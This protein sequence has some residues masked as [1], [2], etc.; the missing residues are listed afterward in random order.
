MSVLDEGTSGLVATSTEQA[1]ITDWTSAVIAEEVQADIDEDPTDAL[2]R[3]HARKHAVI[4]GG[5]GLIAAPTSLES[6]MST[7]ELMARLSETREALRR[8][9][10]A[11]EAELGRPS[12][13]SH[14]D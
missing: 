12:G 14:T 4:D 6:E 8:A 5:G 3:S 10:G 13:E 1:L 2:V 7:A 11:S 9:L